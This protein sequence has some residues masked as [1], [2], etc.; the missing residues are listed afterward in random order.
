MAQTNQIW[1]LT[2]FLQVAQKCAVSTHIAFFKIQTGF[3]QFVAM[4]TK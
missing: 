3:W 4:I 2:E 1:K